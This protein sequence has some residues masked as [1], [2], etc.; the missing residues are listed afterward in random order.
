LTDT[1]T[2]LL[3]QGTPAQAAL[4]GVEPDRLITY[5]VLA[6]N[7]EML[8]DRIAASGLAPGS[9]IAI[10][11]PNGPEFVFAFLAVLRARAVAA[12]FNTA[13]SGEF[14][15]LWRDG[16]IRAVIAIADDATSA[17]HARALRIPRWTLA[18]DGVGRVT[19]DLPS[20]QTR[21]ASAPQPDD[22]A[23]F[24]Y[25]SGTTSKPKGV[26]LTHRNLMASVANIAECYRLMPNDR[27]LLVMPLFH[28]HGLIGATLSTLYAGGAVIAPPRFS[29]SAF[30]PTAQAHRA[31]W[32]SA[33]P[34]IHRTLLL[35][36]ATDAPV[37]YGF[38]FI[39]SCSSAL[40]P[41][42]LAQMEDR[43][44]APVLEAYG[45]TEA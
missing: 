12:P 41:T 2:S 38:R 6:E 34:T 28:V 36:A 16:A 5:R 45:M 31:T 1:I 27:T 10:V 15:A 4:I 17:D 22:V 32:Y 7:V 25:T 14:Q 8:A 3:T 23:L 21:T 35:R 18:T 13:Q 19:L 37:R 44:Q 9:R 33:V 20:S 43:F 24:L 11:L 42:M 29:A 39:R 26:P 40:A 30:W